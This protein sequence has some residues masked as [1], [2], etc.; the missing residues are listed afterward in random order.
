M[1][2]DVRRQLVAEAE[3]GRKQPAEGRDGM[4]ISSHPLVTR[5]GVEILRAGGNAVDAV[6]GA[7]AMQVV[8]EPHMTTVCGVLSL[9]HHDAAT[10]ESC[11][12]NGSMNAP[13]APLPGFGMHDL[14]TG[15]GVSVPGWAAAFEA[16]RARL[17]TWSR[18][19]LLQPAI[20]MARDGFEIHP[21][22]YGMMFEQ[23]GSLGR[24]QEGRSIYMPEGALLSPGRMLRQPELAR[25]LE[26]FASL[27]PDHF[28]RGDW[29]RRFV[30][31]VREAGGV[32]TLE[33]LDRYEVRWQEPARSSYRNYTTLGSPPPDN[34]G[35]H[36]L[37][38]LN[39][40]ERLDLETWGPPTESADS[41]YWLMRFCGEVHADG[42]R[43]RDPAYFPMPLETILSKQWAATRFELMQMAAPLI[44][45]RATAPYPGSNHLSVVDRDGNAVTLLHSVMSMPWANG[46]FVDGV[47][48]WA[49]GM[50][51]LRVMPEPGGRAS[52]YVGPTMV[53]DGDRPVIVAGSPSVSLI[54]TIVQNILNLLD[55]GLDV[56]TSVHL[57]RFGGTSLTAPTNPPG[58]YIEADIDSKLQAEMRR[59]G[60]AL[61]VRNPWDFLQGSF[62]GIHCGADGV[63]HACADPR[64]TGKAE[65]V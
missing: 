25:T 29:A 16:A 38:I 22:L 6:L 45:E 64:R 32:L 8:V 65:A 44:P 53:L 48:V 55:F 7:A 11:Y 26:A 18:E 14:A 36:V 23:A 40:V 43:Q 58:Y 10:G 63:L 42:A 13:L 51:F 56:E 15:R 27:G 3:F 31:A 59:R 61:D 34:G 1:Q 46:L 17:G 33:D 60:L 62:E 57:P 21:F 9:L 5:T 35:T 37:E 12:L 19:R 54:P 4:V 39:L 20:D 41:L 28:Y 47:P 2:D 30:D 52:C 24:T 50:H 49:G